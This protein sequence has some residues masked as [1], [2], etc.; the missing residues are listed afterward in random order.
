MCVVSQQVGKK[1]V[2]TI[3]VTR[4]IGLPDLARNEVRLFTPPAVLTFI[5]LSA[6]A[7]CVRRVARATGQESAF[8]ATR[9]FIETITWRSLTAPQRR[10]VTELEL[11]LFSVGS[12][13]RH[14]ITTKVAKFLR[15]HWLP[16]LV[17]PECQ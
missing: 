5:G 9:P 4:R 13:R 2:P 14:L 1:C 6:P 8:A 15:P 3:Q 16:M 17:H 11:V 12:T 10:R 7:P